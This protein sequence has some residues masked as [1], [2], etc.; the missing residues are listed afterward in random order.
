MPITIILAGVPFSGKTVSAATFPKPMLFLDW[1]GKI[2][3]I[4]NTLDK[5]GKPIVKDADQILFQALFQEEQQKITLTA[6]DKTK[7]PPPQADIALSLLDKYNKIVGEIKK[8]QFKTLVI[9]SISTM[10]RIWKEAFLRINLLSSLRIQDYGTLEGVL[11]GQFFPTLKALPVDFV[12]LTDHTDYDKDEL[13]GKILEFPVGPSRAMGR[14]MC[15]AVGNV[16]KQC[17]EGGEYL[18]RTKPVDFFQIAGSDLALPEI[19]KPSTYYEL[20]KYLP[21]KGGEN[22]A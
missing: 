8:D 19:I 2:F 11:F 13:I 14:T 17:V 6:G 15:K 12:I 21:K 3:S 10:F 5:T 16:W 1:D 20:E 22:N 18:W 4:F 7:M 9:D